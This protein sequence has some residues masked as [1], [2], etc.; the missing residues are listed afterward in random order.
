MSLKKQVKAFVF[1]LIIICSITSLTSVPAQ[2][3]DDFNNYHE[4]DLKLNVRSA[5]AI[6]SNTGQLLYAK[7][8]NKKLPIASMT[9]LITIYLTLHAIQHHQ[10]SWNTKVKP[11]AS[12]CKV[13][14]NKEYSNVP[15][16]RGHYYAVKQLYQATLIESANGA[17][18]CLAE[19]IAGSQKSFVDLMR[20]QVQKWQINKAK[21][22]T[23]CGLANGNVGRDAYPGVKKNAENELSARDMAVISMQLLK[24]YP[25]L[26]KTTKLAHLDFKDQGR[27]TKMSNFNWMLKGLSQYS[28]ALPVDGLKTGT[29]DKAGA[30]FVG[31]LPVKK[32]RIITVV[33]GAS[34][35]DGN[36]PA[37]FWQTKKLMSYCLDSYQPVYLRKGEQISGADRIAVVNGKSSTANVGMDKASSIW[38]Y[39]DGKAL[40]VKLNPDQGNAPFYKGKTASYYQ[41]S[42]GKANLPS[43][44]DVK[45]KQYKT[46][47]LNIPA[48]SLSDVDQVN[49]FVRIWHWIF[50]GR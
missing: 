13:A 12:I 49:I 37:R 27:V 43:I 22:Y 30:C 18:M 19:K 38:D 29:T 44:Y 4:N 46:S 16:H 5:I 17:A 1:G 3:A 39:R 2:A 7:D 8:A 48:A 15:L 50:G 42:S 35:K 34:H 47:S 26:L 14:N 23:A 10:L 21:I 6:D 36:D 11:T 31:T 41:F 9:K 20:R 25:Q 33:M 40:K 32:S 45:S 24:E 28:K